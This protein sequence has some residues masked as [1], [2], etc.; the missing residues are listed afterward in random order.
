[1]HFLAF[2]ACRIYKSGKKIKIFKLKKKLQLIESYQLSIETLMEEIRSVV[3]MRKEFER[4]EILVS[5]FGLFGLQEFKIKNKIRDI[6]LDCFPSIKSKTLS[7]E[8]LTEEM[9]Q[10]TLKEI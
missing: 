5:F 9:N 1:M 2:F 8:K 10:E 6:I 7:I 3:L 4:F